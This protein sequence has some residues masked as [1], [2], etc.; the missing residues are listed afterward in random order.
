[1]GV[2]FEREELLGAWIR[3]MELNYVKRQKR[4]DPLKVI[5]N[6]KVYIQLSE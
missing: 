3:L 1:M 5:P 4:A 2:Y 6:D